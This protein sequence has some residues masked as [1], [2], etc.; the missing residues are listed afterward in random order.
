MKGNLSLDW[1]LKNLAQRTGI[2]AEMLRQRCHNEYGMSPGA[3][4]SQLRMT[5]A[6]KMLSN[7][8]KVEYVAQ[9]VGYDTPSNF[10]TAFHRIMGVLPSS[11]KGSQAPVP[12][13]KSPLNR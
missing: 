4:L 2:N 13:S 5:H 3:Y 1:T 7:G 6:A 9:M 8:L 10:S 12:I 11:L